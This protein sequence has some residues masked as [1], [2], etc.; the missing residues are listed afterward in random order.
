MDEL[1]KAIKAAQKN[2][3]SEHIIYR[4]LS[5]ATKQPRNRDVLA[6]ISRD[7]LGHYR[8][9]KKYTGREEKPHRLKVCFYVLVARLFG[10]TFGIKL[11]ERGEDKAQDNYR[12]L[13]AKVP[14]AMD[15]ARDEDEHEAQ[16]IRMIN[17]ERLNY[18]GA[19]IRGLNDALVELTG[20][21][22]GLTLALREPRLIAMTGLITGIAASLSMAGTEYLAS[23][24]EDDGRSPLKSSLYTGVAYVVTVAFL[25]APYLLIDNVYLSLGLMICIAILIIIVFNFY[26][27]VAKDTPFWKR[28]SEMAALSLGIAAISFGIGFLVREAFGVEV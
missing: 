19:M 14:Q 26:L 17:E 18:V 25:I 24:S 16:L 22:A 21:L 10:L 13:A 9:W 28:F 8:I 5:R 4:S 12:S 2:E 1:E 6:K 3:I 23:K 7:E 27:S 15:I 11:M 20:A